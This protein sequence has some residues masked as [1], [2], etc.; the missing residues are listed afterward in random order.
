[1]EARASSPA[2]TPQRS[3]LFEGVLGPAGG[4]PHRSCRRPSLPRTRAH[5]KSHAP[6]SKT[7]ERRAW[8]G[9]GD[10]PKLVRET[11]PSR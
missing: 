7:K 9:E 5:A 3:F 10:P 2:S 6:A 11:S 8:S 1:M 4:G